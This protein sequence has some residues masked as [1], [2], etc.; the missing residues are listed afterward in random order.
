MTCCLPVMTYKKNKESCEAIYKQIAS[1]YVVLSF[2]L[3]DFVGLNINPTMSIPK[4]SDHIPDLTALGYIQI[5][6]ITHFG[7]NVTSQEKRDILNSLLYA[8]T[9]A[10][11]KSKR[12]EKPVDWYLAYAQVLTRIGYESESMKTNRISKFADG[13]VTLADVVIKNLKEETSATV[14]AAISSL[15]NELSSLSPPSEKLTMLYSNSYSS[16]K[17]NYCFQVNCVQKDP[18]GS[19]SVMLAMFSF[20]KVNYNEHILNSIVKLPDVGLFRGFYTVGFNPQ[21]YAAIRKSVKD[22]T[23]KKAGEM[24]TAIEI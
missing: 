20:S 22:F 14:L 1:T 5:G 15:I 9:S 2:L 13:K 10:D 12:A 4:G 24:L 21:L 8:Q 6:G 7:E 17:G 23:L 16:S 11:D 3:G 18:D 19:I